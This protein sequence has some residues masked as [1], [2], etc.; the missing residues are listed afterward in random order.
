MGKLRTFSPAPEGDLCVGGRSFRRAAD[1]AAL[2]VRNEFRQVVDPGT[3]RPE[4]GTL[5]EGKL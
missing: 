1:P 4:V 3:G 5:L 2:A